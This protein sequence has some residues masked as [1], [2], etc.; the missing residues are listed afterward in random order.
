MGSDVESAT[1]RGGTGSRVKTRVDAVNP[2]ARAFAA[3]AA[4]VKSESS[5]IN[6]VV[7]SECSSPNLVIKTERSSSSTSNSVVKS[8]NSAANLVMNSVKSENTSSSSDSAKA[9]GSCRG[10][11]A[12]LGANAR[13]RCVVRSDGCV[14]IEP[15]DSQHSTDKVEK[16]LPDRTVKEELDDSKNR[17]L[18]KRSLPGKVIAR[19]SLKLRKVTHCR[20]QS[21]HPLHQPQTSGEDNAAHTSPDKEASLSCLTQ[22]SADKKLSQMSLCRLRSSLGS[23]G[24]SVPV[25]L[26]LGEVLLALAGAHPRFSIDAPVAGYI[27]DMLK[28]CLAE[29][30]PEWCLKPHQEDG[31]R[32]LMNR[33]ALRLGSILADDMGLGKTRQAIA[34][35]FGIRSALSDASSSIADNTQD[36]AENCPFRKN[37][38]CGKEG[39]SHPSCKPVVWERALVVA[40]AMLVRGEDSLWIKELREAE[41]LWGRRCNVW[42]WHGER[43]VD[44]RSTIYRATWSGP[45]LELF[46]VVVVSYES[47]LLNQEEFC[48]ENWTC[49]IL[50]EAQSIK[51]RRSQIA[52]ATK[53][54][55]RAPFRLAMTGTPIENSVADFHSILQ[56][57]QPDCA[58][59]V[60]EFWERFPPTEDG[61]ATLRRLLP[62]VALRRESGVAVKMVPKEEQEIPVSMSDLQQTVYS[63]AMEQEISA[64]KRI[65]NAELVCSHPWCYAAVANADAREK[66]PQH[67]LGEAVDQRISDSR[68][69]EELFRILKGLLSCRQK[70]LLFFCRTITSDLVAALI[71]KEFGIQPGIVRGDTASGE[72]DRLIREFRTDPETDAPHAQVLLLSVW[73]GAVGLNI[74]EARWVV[75][76]ER[77]WNPALER[78]ATS[79]VHRINSKHPVKAYC[80]YTEGT[81]EEHKRTVLMQKHQMSTHIID[82]LDG[83]LE[84]DG[85]EVQ[86]MPLELQELVSGIAG[87]QKQKSDVTHEADDELMLDAGDGQEDAVIDSDDDEE[88]A[89]SGAKKKRENHGLYPVFDKI[90]PR[91]LVEPMKGKY[92]DPSLHELWDWYV[93]K[94]HRD[95]HT[96]ALETSTAG[97]H[98]QGISGKQT[99][100]VSALSARPARVYDIKAREDWVVEVHC[101]GTACRLFIP[102]QLRKYFHQANAG[103]L[104]FRQ[105]AS[106]SIP[107]P[108]LMPSFCRSALDAEVG[109]L[110]LTGTMVQSDGSALEFLQIVAV[111]PS[112]VEKYRSSG[113]FFV[114]MELPPTHIC[115]HPLYG[116]VSPEEL[117]IG[118]A[119]HWLMRLASALKMKHIFM[120]DDSVRAWRGTTLVNDP[121]SVFGHVAG[122]KAQFR[123]ISLASVLEHF[124]APDF[125]SEFSKFSVL[126]FPRFSPE[127]Y[128]TRCAYRRQHVYSAFLVNV[129]R[130]LHEQGMNF[131]ETSFIWEDVDFNARVKDV[132]K[133]F[134]FVMI[135]KPYNHGG[136]TEHIARCENPIVR[137]PLFAKFSPAEIAVEAL[138]RN[139]LGYQ[140]PK[141]PVPL[142]KKSKKVAVKAEIDSEQDGAAAAELLGR[143]V[144]ELEADAALQPEGAV[145]NEN[146]ILVRSYYTRFIEAFR[147]KERS[148][149]DL[150]TGTVNRRPGMRQNEEWPPGFRFWDDTKNNKVRRK[151]KVK[152]SKVAKQVW[153]AGWI[154]P[155]PF[156]KRE[157]HATSQWFNVR[158]WKTWR[159][160]FLLARLQSAVWHAKGRADGLEPCIR[161]PVKRKQKADA[162]DSGTKQRKKRLAFRRRL[163]VETK[164]QPTLDKFFPA[165]IKKEPESS[166]P[167]QPDIRSFFK[168]VQSKGNQPST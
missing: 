21:G 35:L 98:R 104:E 161:T 114:V 87:S 116:A 122:K 55:S 107:F 160:A 56:F 62:L 105:V 24:S 31:Y 141:K 65:K 155:Y 120:M 119:R 117:G 112:E 7:K 136:C 16:P 127:L 1:G 111:K 41:K 162:P 99:H 146:G 140:V 33:S 103:E 40:P 6:P 126:G 148:C 12:K 151:V 17:L 38:A 159:L 73:V 80:L 147:E 51:N 36:L 37:M 118:C 69:M 52:E 45:M 85:E 60:H 76:L 166:A 42:Q 75:H 100:H 59:T 123:P 71:G 3:G 57:V 110:D 138:E 82:A 108:I 53:K 131:K 14:V 30:R 78:Q 9:K 5:T 39:C 142:P 167:P 130:V 13:F 102:A 89:G 139:S 64:I 11:F 134:R 101:D 106:G 135:K 156:P 20:V 49:V 115:Q 109:M 10:V 66:L 113:P 54:L 25:G 68:K 28:P 34:W 90:K 96:K 32:W 44:L 86:T 84:C 18:R 121:H 61:R 124:A 22:I 145:C 46:D 157:G 94:G 92:G 23:Q 144:F 133:C 48:K 8:E 128:R 154:A 19:R 50:D 81:V 63:I 67:L 153:G 143:S 88:G 29:V 165:K 129:N 93:E 83:D 43:A 164:K 70:V 47:F 27:R 26:S 4:P 132:C 91:T 137:A 58:G 163:F 152:G 74:P 72:R 149:V 95:V 97:L 168:T 15:D 79:R 125:L 158:R 77:V 150:T 2:L